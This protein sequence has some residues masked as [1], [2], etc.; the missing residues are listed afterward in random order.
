MIQQGTEEWLRA[1]CGNI[2]CSRFADVMSNGRGNA[3]SKT[4][5]TY[6]DELLA[7]ILTGK[8]AREVK[9]FAM[10]WGT[11]HEPIARE[12]YEQRTGNKVTDGGII[13]HAGHRI[14]G[15]P[16]GLVGDDGSIE[17][18]CPYTITP[19]M[20][21]VESLQIP[22]EHWEQ[23]Q[24]YLWI[25]GREWCDFISYHPDFPEQFQLI[26]VRVAANKEYHAELQAKLYAFEAALL[27][28]VKAILERMKGTK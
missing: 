1:R 13:K 2:T 6:Q 21:V 14:T 24:G 25:T 17:I 15:S 11:T 20:R 10:E 16:D 18:K 22:D 8:P 28:R 12:L 23:V 26:V 19:H 4:A 3:P 27:S 9:T 5:Q 7:E